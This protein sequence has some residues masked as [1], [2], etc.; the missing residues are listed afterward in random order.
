LV[1]VEH[2]ELVAAEI[3]VRLLAT[4]CFVDDIVEDGPAWQRTYVA[5]ALEAGCAGVMV[6]ADF[7]CRELAKRYPDRYFFQ[8][9]NFVQ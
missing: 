8:L 6:D 4:S 3:D 1:H 9:P 5:M 7:D 2:E